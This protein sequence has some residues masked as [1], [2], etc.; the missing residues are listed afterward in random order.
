MAILIYLLSELLPEIYWEQVTEEILF[1]FYFD[2]WGSKP[3]LTSNKPTH[4]LL[5]QGGFIF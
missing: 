2:V 4:Y 1:V 5:D 3:G